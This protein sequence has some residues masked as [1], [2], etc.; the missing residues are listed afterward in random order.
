MLSRL[1][2]FLAKI[3][4]GRL[5]LTLLAAALACGLYGVLF[6]AVKY[7]LPSSPVDDE[8]WVIFVAVFVGVGLVVSVVLV[9]LCLPL[10]YMLSRFNKLKPAYIAPLAFGVGWFVGYWTQ[11]LISFGM[12]S[13]GAIGERVLFVALNGSVGV[14]GALILYWF[15]LRHVYMAKNASNE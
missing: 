13:E 8:A 6:Y 1:T 4:F 5:L 14:L 3:R 9:L 11:I 2:T 10:A 15:Y 12:Y 7:A